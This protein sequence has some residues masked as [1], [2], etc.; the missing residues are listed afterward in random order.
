MKVKGSVFCSV[1][2]LG[3]VN[4]SSGLWPKSGELFQPP[5]MFFKVLIELR[6]WVRRGLKIK[7]LSNLLIILI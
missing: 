7:L 2:D 5:F 3:V 4:Q 1:K 6:F